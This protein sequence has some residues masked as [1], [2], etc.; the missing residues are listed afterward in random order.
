VRRIGPSSSRRSRTARRSCAIAEPLQSLRMPVR[1]ANPNTRTRKRAQAPSHR[2]VKCRMKRPAPRR[3]FRRRAIICAHPLPPLPSSRPPVADCWKGDVV[4]PVRARPAIG[5]A[6]FFVGGV[7]G[8]D[9]RVERFRASPDR[10][11]A[12]ARALRARSATAVDRRQ[13]AS[14]SRRRARSARSRAR[15]QQK[16]VSIRYSPASSTTRTSAAC[17]CTGQEVARIAAASSAAAFR[18]GS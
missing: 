3:L 10:A 13:L 2:R 1:S 9:Y 17:P 18:G 11:G 6:R 15:S 14:A 7:L 5:S 8:L 16:E 12:T 4:T